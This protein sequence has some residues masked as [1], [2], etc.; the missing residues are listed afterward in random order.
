[1]GLPPFHPNPSVD[2]SLEKDI[3]KMVVSPKDMGHNDIIQKV[4]DEERDVLSV[5][6]TDV[7]L[8]A[9]EGAA[10][11]SSLAKAI[12][13]KWRG[14]QLSSDEGLRYL[15]KAAMKADE[16]RSKAILDEMGLGGD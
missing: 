7:L 12:L 1:M 5:N 11:P 2:S 15:L 13:Y 10:V 8:E 4:K 9:K 3:V 14:D 6:L 16:E